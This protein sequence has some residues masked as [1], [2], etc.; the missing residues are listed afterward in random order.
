MRLLKEFDLAVNS[1][2]RPAGMILRRVPKRPFIYYVSSCLGEWVQKLAIF[3]SYHAY[4]H[5]GWG[6][7]GVEKLKK[8]K[9]MLT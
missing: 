1:A 8:S 3:D 9:I 7:G 2:K 4:L 5:N 6:M